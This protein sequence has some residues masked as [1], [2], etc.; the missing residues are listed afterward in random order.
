MTLTAEQGKAAKELDYLLEIEIGHR[1]DILE[2]LNPWFDE[3]GGLFSIIYPY[4][5]VSKVKECVLSGSLEHVITTYAPVGDVGECL[6][7]PSSWFY[8][9]T[10]SIP[11]LYIHTSTDADPGGGDFYVCAYFWECLCN[12]QRE[13]SQ[14]LYNNGVWYLPYLDESSIP[15]VSLEVSMFSEGG[16]RQSFGTILLLNADG[17]FDSRIADYIYSGKRAVLKV[18][19]PND[20][21]VD[22]VTIWRGWTGNL[23]WSDERL[24]IDTEDE[25]KIAE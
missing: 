12:G 7:Y 21:Y 20:A 15:D 6:T 10:S 1:I 17:Y 2:S 16:I 5:V 9:S 4:G 18:G 25:R 22:F 13:G 24:T 3:G 8:D 14:A 19:A 23:V 11:I